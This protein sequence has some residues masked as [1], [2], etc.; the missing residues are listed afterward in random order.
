[1][2]WCQR[3]ARRAPKQDGLRLARNLLGPLVGRELERT[4]KHVDGHAAMA[5]VLASPEFQRR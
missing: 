2:E 3:A 4:L 5:I 1:M